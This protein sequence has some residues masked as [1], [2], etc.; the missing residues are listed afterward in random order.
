[1]PHQYVSGD[2]TDSISI[3]RVIDA[4]YYFLN[5]LYIKVIME[6]NKLHFTVV[7]IKQRHI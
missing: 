6:R 7:E 1:M 3:I 4:A 5:I 2:V